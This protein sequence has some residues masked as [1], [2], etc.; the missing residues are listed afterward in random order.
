MIP[1][2][3]AYHGDSFNIALE[4]GRWERWII[5]RIS[6]DEGNREQIVLSQKGMDELA[7]YFAKFYAEDKAA[8]RF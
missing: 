6:D 8:P 2:E 7:D 1:T 5:W 4:K 3:D